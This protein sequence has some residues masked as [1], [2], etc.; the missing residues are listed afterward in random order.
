MLG[1]EESLEESAATAGVNPKSFTVSGMLSAGPG[2][3]T[4]SAEVPCSQTRALPGRR[5][6]GLRHPWLRHFLGQRSS[7]YL[8]ASD[9][10]FH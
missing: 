7:F 1:G 8:I 2:S 5:T 4:G 10:F 3:C 9:V 6:A